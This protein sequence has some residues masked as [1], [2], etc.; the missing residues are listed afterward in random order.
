[1]PLGQQKPL[2]MGLS[3]SPLIFSTTWPERVISRPQPASHRGQVRKA[4]VWLII[5]PD[6][7]KKGR[8]GF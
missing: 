5:S 6:K 3:L 8:F 2:L 1:M 7:S 4:V